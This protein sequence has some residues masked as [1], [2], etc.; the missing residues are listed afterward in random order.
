MRSWARGLAPQ[1]RFPPRRW[2]SPAH[3]EAATHLSPAVPSSLFS[4]QLG[5]SPVLWLEALNPKLNLLASRQRAH[6]RRGSHP[7][8]VPWPG[9]PG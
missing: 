4:P 9:S 7:A 2:T 8:R 3:L 5:R 6:F 1:T